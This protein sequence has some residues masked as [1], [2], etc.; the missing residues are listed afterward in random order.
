MASNTN[1]SVTGFWIYTVYA[2]A[3]YANARNGTISSAF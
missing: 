1:V 3:I 2:T